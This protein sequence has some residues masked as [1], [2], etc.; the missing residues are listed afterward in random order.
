MVS[1][2]IRDVPQATRDALAALAAA[3][4][5]SLQAFLRD[6]L[7]QL[8]SRPER[9]EVLSRIADR[10]EREG[11]AVSVDEILDARDADRR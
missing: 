5:R 11:A 10:V 4:G 8:A 1:I 2:T 7:I 9:S 6:H 3:A